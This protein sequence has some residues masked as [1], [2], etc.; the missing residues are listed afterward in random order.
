MRSTGIILLSIATLILIS[1]V[2]LSAYNFPFPPIF[3]LTVL[4]Q[5]I[6]MVSVYKILTDNYHTDKIFED[7]Y[8]DCPHN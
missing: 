8:E 5:L 6:F 2:I 4:G 7:W 1:L 3:Y